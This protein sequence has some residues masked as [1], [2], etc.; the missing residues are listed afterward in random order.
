MAGSGGSQGLS[1]MAL[2]M[3]SSAVMP[4]AAP[5]QL[6]P[7]I[8]ALVITPL[9]FTGCTFNPWASLGAIKWFQVLT[10][11]NT[12]T[13]AAEGLRFAMVPPLLGHTPGTL[14]LG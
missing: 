12:L 1:A 3:A 4:W 10:L 9:T 11:C 6:L 13:Y 8:L 7:I 2:L 14:A 5:V